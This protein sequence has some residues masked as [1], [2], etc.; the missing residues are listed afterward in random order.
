MLTLRVLWETCTTIQHH[1]YTRGENR[2]EN[3]TSVT[4]GMC[5]HLR[6]V[7]WTLP[8]S[9]LSQAKSG[10]ALIFLGE[11]SGIQKHSKRGRVQG[12]DLTKLQTEASSLACV[13]IPVV[14]WGP[15]DSSLTDRV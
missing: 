12:P 2:T 3:Q 11:K 9:E 10:T 14:K 4:P 5:P 1:I 6:I 13:H 8:G 15:A 7:T